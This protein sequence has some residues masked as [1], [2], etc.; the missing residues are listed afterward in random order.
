MCI[1][2]VDLSSN[3]NNLLTF[4]DR[5]TV[6]NTFMIS[7]AP[8]S[9]VIILVS[10][11]GSTIISIPSINIIIINERYIHHEVVLSFLNFN[12]LFKLISELNININPSSIF[13][14]LIIHVGSTN[15]EILSAIDAILIIM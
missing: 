10:H 1:I 6:I 14:T 8:A 11:S 2:S 4:F 7:D 5:I 12:I 9:L 13:N 3:I 15:I